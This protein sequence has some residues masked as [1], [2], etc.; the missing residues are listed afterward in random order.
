VAGQDL[1]PGYGQLGLVRVYCNYSPA[2][3]WVG[4]AWASTVKMLAGERAF[5]WQPG[6]GWIA[7]S[8]FEEASGKG[9]CRKWRDTLF[10]H[11]PSGDAAA[12]AAGG[13]DAGPEQQQPTRKECVRA[14]L[15]L[16]QHGVAARKRGRAGA[17]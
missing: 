10:M 12:A 3:G 5:V 2:E 9:N 13:L 4:C 16:D 8:A 15:W 1:P 7:A 11:L 6:E 14:G 17:H